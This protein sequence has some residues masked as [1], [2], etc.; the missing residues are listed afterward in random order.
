VIVVP[1]AHA[2]RPV[3]LAVDDDPGGLERTEGELRKRYEADYGVV[4]GGGEGRLERLILEGSIVIRLVHGYLEE[5][6][7]WTARRQVSGNRDY[8]SGS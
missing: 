4:G 3:I 1:E 6:T 2:F 5:S 7:E 8:A